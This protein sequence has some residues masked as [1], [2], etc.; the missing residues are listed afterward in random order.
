MPARPNLVLG[1]VWSTH[2]LHPISILSEF[3]NDVIISSAGCEQ[4]KTSLYS[5]LWGRPVSSSG[6]LSAEIIMMTII[7]TWIT[8]I[9][10]A[11]KNYDLV[12]KL[13]LHL[14]DVLMTQILVKWKGLILENFLNLAR[15]QA[16]HCP[17]NS[18]AELVAQWSTLQQTAK[19]GI[20]RL[21][22]FK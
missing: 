21:P 19:V 14:G 8:L 17:T 6:R 1:S 15:V 22:V 18:K 13:L 4:R 9:I 20:C 11:T 7:I 3:R 10:I 2:I 5:N 12:N 16:K